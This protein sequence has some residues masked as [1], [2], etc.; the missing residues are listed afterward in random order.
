MQA[1][2]INYTKKYPIVEIFKSIEGE[3]IRTGAPTVF[4]RFGYVI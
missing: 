4:V 3:G 2:K 1:N